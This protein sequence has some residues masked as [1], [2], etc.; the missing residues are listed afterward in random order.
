MQITEISADGLKREFKV[1]IAAQE[2][3][4]K[5]QAKL[6]EL[7]RTVKL[8]GFRPGKVPLVEVTRRFA[9]SVNQEVV[10]VEIEASAKQALKD[11]GLRPALQPA[12]DA[13]PYEAGRDLEYTMRVELMPDIEPADFAGIEL[14]RP[15]AEVDDAAIDTMLASLAEFS[16][17]TEPLTE[18]RGA[19]DGDAVIIDFNGTVNGVAMDGM[20]AENHELILGQGSFLPEFESGLQGARAGEHR[21]LTINFP[22]DYHG[23]EVAGQQGIFELD[24]KDVRTRL[25]V[26]VDDELAKRYGMESVEAL[27]TSARERLG[28]EYAQLSRR[29]AKRLL[30]DKLAEV[31][32]FP[33]PPSM[34]EYEFES[35]WTEWQAEKTGGR[36]PATELERDEEVVKAEYRAIS[37]R[38]VRLGLLLSEIARRNN[39][40]VTQEE[41]NRAILAEARRY[42]GHEREV[43]DLFRKNEHA[44]DRLK[45]PIY[46]DKTVDFILELIRVTDRT[47]S[48]EDL[49]KEPEEI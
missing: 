31:N 9:S 8:P 49:R 19:A 36:L 33:V 10:E 11:R 15:V 5:I 32:Q 43:L 28:K 21:Q 4:T 30:L 42:P 41:V 22:A 17:K 14:E 46:E 24:I 16:R 6:K 29:R 23:K 2:I 44:V 1:V 37:E 20:K 38:R 45:A 39:I 12:I 25:P 13:P 35:V 48:I 34:V 40:K 47:V 3:D 27:R 18:D 7:C 26:V